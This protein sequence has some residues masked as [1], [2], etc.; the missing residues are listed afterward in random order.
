MQLPLSLLFGLLTRLRCLT[1]D[2]KTFSS[3]TRTPG[4]P[5]LRIR[6]F[7]LSLSSYRFIFGM[8]FDS[9]PDRSGSPQEHHKYASRGDVPEPRFWTRMSM[10]HLS[11]NATYRELPPTISVVRSNSGRARLSVLGCS[12]LLVGHQ[13]K[14]ASKRHSQSTLIC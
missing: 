1:L 5:I 11:G 13:G 10:N 9:N 8:E 2:K 4:F 7:L 14:A 3:K 12:W 6:A